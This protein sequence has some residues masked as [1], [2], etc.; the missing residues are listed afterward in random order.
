MHSQ[1][2]LR[3]RATILVAA[4]GLV[5]G[6]IYRSEFADFKQYRLPTALVA[7]SKKHLLP[8]VG[9]LQPPSRTLIAL[10]THGTRAPTTPSSAMRNEDTSPGVEDVV[11]TARPVNVPGAASNTNSSVMRQWVDELTG[12]A[13]NAE[14]GLRVPSEAE[15]THVTS[16]FPSLDRE[17]IVAALQ[18][19]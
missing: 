1:M 18:R 19:R 10:P 3:T 12:R 11:T 14:A 15:I 17:V 7:F 5:A 13:Q 4:I 16:M 8:F 6:Q 2:A 9:S